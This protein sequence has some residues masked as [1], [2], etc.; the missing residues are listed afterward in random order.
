MSLVR[1]KRLFS[2]SRESHRH[3]FGKN[4]KIMI[5]DRTQLAKPPVS[6]LTEAFKFHILKR[7]SALRCSLVEAKKSIFFKFWRS[8][9]FENIGSTSFSVRRCRFLSLNHRISRVI[10]S[11]R[12]T[13]WPHSLSRVHE[14]RAAGKRAGVPVERGGGAPRTPGDNAPRPRS[15]KKKKM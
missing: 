11:D 3:D 1:L 13:T 15:D 8:H 9:N 7:Q 2:K 14:A 12:R 6:T 4:E 10:Y 5:F